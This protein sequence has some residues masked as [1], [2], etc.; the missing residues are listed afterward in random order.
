[1]QVND[2]LVS[3]WGYEQTNIDFYKVL[4]V[5]PSTVI[6]QELE[7]IE[8]NDEDMSG[9]VM[10]IDKLK[11]KPIRRKIH[12]FNNE[13]FIYITSYSIAQKWDKKKQRYTSYC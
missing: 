6:V 11:G 10:P 7:K 12:T 3:H 13:K 1:M 9:W 8:H 5:T 4:K 2:I